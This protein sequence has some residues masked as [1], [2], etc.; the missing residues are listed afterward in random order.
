LAAAAAGFLWLLDA[1]LG[2]AVPSPDPA[3][4]TLVVLPPDASLLTP[5]VDEVDEVRL[6]AT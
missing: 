6:G 3:L 2:L 4:L 5:G 1:T